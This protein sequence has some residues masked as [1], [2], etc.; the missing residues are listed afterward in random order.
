[1]KLLLDQNLSPRLIPRLQKQFPASAHI[2]EF[3]LS[4]ATDAEIWTF[5][6]QNAFVILTKDAD[7]NDRSEIFGAPPKVIWLRSGNC[8]V[9]D[10]ENVLHKHY[11]TIAHFIADSESRLLTII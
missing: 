6:Q 2:R 8:S 4:D 9:V 3:G 1:M 10:V 11:A 7:F 5:A